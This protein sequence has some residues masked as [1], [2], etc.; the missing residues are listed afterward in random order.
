MNIEDHEKKEKEAIFISELLCIWYL[1]YGVSQCP[2]RR[3]I[4]ISFFFFQD[5][6]VPGH[7]TRGVGLKSDPC[8]SNFKADCYSL[9]CNMFYQITSLITTERGTITSFCWKNYE[10]SDEK[11]LCPFLCITVKYM[12]VM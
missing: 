8:K 11:A 7:T 3:T 6:F 12:C 9:F 5:S 4:I 1:T 2:C 10:L